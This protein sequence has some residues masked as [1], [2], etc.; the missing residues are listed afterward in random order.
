MVE[1]IVVDYLIL[2]LDFRKYG[3][4]VWKLWEYFEKIILSSKNVAKHL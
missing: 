3:N 2:F 4:I 1:N